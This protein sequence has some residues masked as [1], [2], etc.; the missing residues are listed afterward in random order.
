MLEVKKEGILLKKTSLGFEN[1]G[2]LNPAVIREGNSVHM[3]YRAVREGNF[4]TIGYCEFDGPLTVKH[5]HNVPVFFPHTEHETHGVEDPR[6]T[7]I[8]GVYYLSYTAYDGVNALGCLAT[9]KD[10]KI[11]NGDGVFVPNINFD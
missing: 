4:S 5:R 3:F 11:F 9:S 2:V 8:D 7:K 10:L 1:E 6:I